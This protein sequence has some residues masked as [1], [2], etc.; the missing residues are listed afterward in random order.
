MR[1]YVLCI[2]FVFVVVLTGCS[3][4]LPK[5]DKGDPGQQGTPGA[6]GEVGVIGPVGSTGEAGVPGMTLIKI[7]AGTFSSTGNLYLDVPEIS[8]KLGSTIVLAYWAFST[9]PSI[10]NPMADGWLDSSTFAKS[11]SVSW[12]FGRVYFYGVTAGDYYLVQVY[13]NN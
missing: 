1:Y 8:G 3:S 11:F 13:Q 4:L 7:Y 12:T 10:W 6:T 2:L 5:G 9:S